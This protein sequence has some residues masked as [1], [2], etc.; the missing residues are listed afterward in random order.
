[1][2]VEIDGDEWPLWSDD[3]RRAVIDH[4]CQHFEVGRDKAGHFTSDDNGRPVISIRPHDWQVGGFRIIAERHGR[5]AFEVQAAM[6]MRKSFGQ[7]LFDFDGDAPD[8][9]QSGP[10]PTNAAFNADAFPKIAE[11]ANAMHGATA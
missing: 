8:A 3:E 2:R 11:M 5:V 9:S 6:A 1:V 4:E 10:R 7:V